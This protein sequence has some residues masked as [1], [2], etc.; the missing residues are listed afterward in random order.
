MMSLNTW[1]FWVGYALL[2]VLTSFFF[3][4]M[5]I[6]I[7][8]KYGWAAKLPTWRSFPGWLKS[9]FSPI[10]PLTG[11]HLYL[12][13]FLFTLGHLAVL[14]SPWSLGRE[15]ILMSFIVVVVTLEDL[16]WFVFNPHF[17]LKRFKKEFAIWHTTW[18]IKFPRIYWVAVSLA[19]VLIYSGIQLN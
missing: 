18:F 17:G 8:G 2:S 11:Y 10:R 15:L 1:R 5:E 6:Q 19:V 13:L 16:F 7:E 4:M 9:F 14:F 3:A 12:W